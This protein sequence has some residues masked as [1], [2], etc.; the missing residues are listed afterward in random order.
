[1]IGSIFARLDIRIPADNYGRSGG[2]VVM[3][4]YVRKQ[5]QKKHD[6]SSSV[7]APVYKDDRVTERPSKSNRDARR[8][9]RET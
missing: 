9:G 5:K 7:G 2:G 8:I 6:F 1:M 4:Q 3:R